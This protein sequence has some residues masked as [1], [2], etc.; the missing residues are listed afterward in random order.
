MSVC[1][2][3]GGASNPSM[4][5]R[6]GLSECALLAALIGSAIGFIETAAHSIPVALPGGI[7]GP[8]LQFGIAPSQ[9]QNFLLE[10]RHPFTFTI[11]FS[12]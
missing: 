7:A 8:A 6:Q 9:A 10:I 12:V 4:S 1:G 3:H 2:K 5:S 11:C